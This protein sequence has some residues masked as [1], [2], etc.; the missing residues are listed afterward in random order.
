MALL[1]PDQINESMNLI[2]YAIVSVKQELE[3]NSNVKF[4]EHE[5]RYSKVKQKKI[6]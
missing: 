3:A 6:Q 4:E 5:L 1:T 2:N